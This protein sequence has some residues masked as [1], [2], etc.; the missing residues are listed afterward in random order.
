LALI[1]VGAGNE[2]GHPAPQLIAELARL[3]MPVARTD[4]QGDIA[5]VDRASRLVPIV[6]ARG[7]SG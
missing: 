2:Y 5:V 4:Q 1:S 6:R 7:A 3:G